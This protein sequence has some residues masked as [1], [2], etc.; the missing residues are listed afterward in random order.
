M[1]LYC[2]DRAISDIYTDY[3]TLEDNYLAVLW[4]SYLKIRH[5]EIEHNMSATEVYV[6]SRASKGSVFQGCIFHLTEDF[7][8]I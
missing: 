3:E 7:L 4:G 8:V 5:L 1:I 2:T 6:G